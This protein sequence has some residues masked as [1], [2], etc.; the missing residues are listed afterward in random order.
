[1]LTQVIPLMGVLLGAATSY[2]ATSSAERA[3]FRQ[4]IATRWDERK[5]D[6]YIEYVTSV[7]EALRE[8]RRA[9][10]AR[11]RGEDSSEAL[12]AMAAAEARRS[13]LFEG[14]VLLADDAAARAAGAVNERLWD[15]LRSAE[16]PA[17]GSGADPEDL[18]SATVEALNTLHKAAR[19]DLATRT[20]LGGGGPA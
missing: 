11:D 15:V 6:T 14:L 1:M 18:R 2:F 16:L 20:R 7:K 9:V 13:V 19:S 5:L 4:T 10:E 17:G 8:A 3:K 12:S